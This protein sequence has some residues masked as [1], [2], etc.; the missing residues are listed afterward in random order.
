MGNGGR[1][2]GIEHLKK[3][4]EDRIWAEKMLSYHYNQKLPRKES[5]MPAELQK[6]AREQRTA[7]SSSSLPSYK[8][9]VLEKL[10][11]WKLPRHQHQ[12]QNQHQNQSAAEQSY[13]DED[14]SI[15]F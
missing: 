7:E 10:L 11:E 1:H 14:A 4:R 15:S 6:W 8:K 9:R 2:E 13:R 12:H 5:S 3:N